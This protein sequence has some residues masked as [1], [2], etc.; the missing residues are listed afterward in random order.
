VCLELKVQ[1]LACGIP[2]K[3]IPDTPLEAIILGWEAQKLK[4]YHAAI[5][6]IDAQMAKVSPV[7]LGKAKG[8]GEKPEDKRHE[9]I[10][11]PIKEQMEA[12]A[13]FKAMPQFMQA[14]RVR[15]QGW[16]GE[17]KGAAT[18]EGMSAQLA[19]ELVA[20]GPTRVE[21][22]AYWTFYRQHYARIN[23]TARG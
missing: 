20:L 8:E 6:H 21:S 4:L 11:K 9:A 23:R 14:E 5:P 13:H 7:A 19:R 3:D 16:P 1:A 18:I 2:L 12:W 10:G 22:P 15:T 17:K